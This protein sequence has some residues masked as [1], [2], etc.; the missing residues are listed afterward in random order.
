MTDQTLTEYAGGLAP[1]A[2]DKAGASIRR[3]AVETALAASSLRVTS[4]FESG[5]WTHGTS[6]SAK[7]D[8]DYMAIATGSRP[9][10]T[11]SALAAAKTA[12]T[13]C[14]W[15]I[16]GVRVSSP[17]IAITYYSQPHFEVA[18]AQWRRAARPRRRRTRC[19]PSWHRTSSFA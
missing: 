4:M 5:S 9:F 15:K 18:P 16:T 14:D 12:V 1:P 3:K 2:Y 11:S 10:W 6:I 7:S 19:A 17:V 13:G 8:V